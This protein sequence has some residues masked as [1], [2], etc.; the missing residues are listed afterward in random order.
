MEYSIFCVSN[1]STDVYKDNKLSTFKNLFPQNLDLK[2]RNWEIGVVSVG[3]NLDNNLLIMSH[4][5][6]AIA[7]FKPKYHSSSMNDFS[8]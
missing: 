3:L 2:N 8:I 1:A 7:L 5:V 6:P 4:Y